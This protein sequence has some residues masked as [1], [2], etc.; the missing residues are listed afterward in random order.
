MTVYDIAAKLPSIGVLRDR[1]RALAVLECIVDGGEPCYAYT[2]AWGDDEAALMSNGSGDEWAVVFT[3]DGAFIRVLDHESA[4]TPYRDP[5]H[6]LWPGLLEGI[7]AVFC[8][9]IEEPAFGDEQGK[10]LATAVLWRLSDDARWHTGEDITFP[11]PR[12][13]YD[14]D[15]DGSHRLEILLDDIVDRYVI[16]AKDHYGIEVD[17]MVIEHVVAHRPLTDVVVQAL[18]PEVTVAR[19]HG[20]I[21]ATGYPIVPV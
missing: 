14:T 1:C 7:P 18:N 12:G 10:F 6:E 8:P 17:P 13:P 16:F 15:P 19:L 4:M 3:A 2:R 21:V 11:P 5:E 20:D 9:Q